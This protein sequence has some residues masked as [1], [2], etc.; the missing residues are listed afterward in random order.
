MR[1][2]RDESTAGVVAVCDLLRCEGL[3]NPKLG[4][5]DAGIA[6]RKV[7]EVRVLEGRGHDADDAVGLAVQEEGLGEDVGAPVEDRLPER[8]TNED[9]VMVLAGLV[10]GG[11]DGVTELGCDLASGE[12]VG[13]DFCG[14]DADD[15][16]CVARGVWGG[17]RE[18][19][20]DQKKVMFE[21]A[22]TLLFEIEE[23]GIAGA[24]DFGREIAFGI[25]SVEVE[26][27]G[28]SRR[29]AESGGEPRG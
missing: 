23:I 24:E 6:V 1:A 9:D 4:I 10:V 8:M 29:R 7:A 15:G 26:R 3:W 12:E 18:G 22:R 14:A 19:E 20:S 28:R 21:K 5:A 13:V 25:G 27:D 11:G 16:V 17:E 2:V